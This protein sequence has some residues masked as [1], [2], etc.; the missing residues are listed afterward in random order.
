MTIDELRKKKAAI[1]KERD[2]FV[3]NANAQVERFIGAL[4]ILEQL[5]AEES[6]N[7]TANAV[8]AG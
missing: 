7:E 1:E 8:D 6:E 5:I 4:A 2:E 3:K